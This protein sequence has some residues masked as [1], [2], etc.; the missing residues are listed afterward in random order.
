MITAEELMDARRVINEAERVLT[1][2]EIDRAAFEQGLEIMRALAR[3]QEAKFFCAVDGRSVPQKGP[4]KD[5][6]AALPAVGATE[7]RDGQRGGGI[8]SS[9]GY[10]ASNPNA[11]CFD[12]VH[13][14]P[15]GRWP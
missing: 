13:A 4:G 6:I 10:F 11:A 5:P 15:H 12:Q 3:R 9:P 7:G 2:R 1:E 8:A 14:H